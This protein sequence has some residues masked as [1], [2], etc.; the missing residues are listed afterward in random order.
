MALSS[1]PEQPVVVDGRRLTCEHVRRVAR[2]QAPVRVHPD[3]VARARAAY[4][5]VRAVQVEQPVYG[6]TTGVGANRSVEV[7]EPAHGLRLLRS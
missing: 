5:A 3:G 4:E 1:V 2:D 6:R 7:T